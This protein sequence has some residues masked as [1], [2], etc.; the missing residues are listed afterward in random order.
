M[1][2]R[3]KATARDIVSMLAER[4]KEDVFV[5][6]CKSGPTQGSEH[7]RL[8]AWAMAKSWA[9]PCFDG[10]EVKISRSDWLRDA[11]V[12][13][14]LPLCNRLWLVCP[15]G[16]IDPAEVP[17]EIGVLWAPKS[18]GTRLVT[19]R[20][21]TYRQIEPPVDL[22]LY[23]L[24]CRSTIGH[25][26]QRAKTRDERAELWRNYLAGRAE[27]KN[28][29]LSASRKMQDEIQRVLAETATVVGRARTQA[30][31]AKAKLRAM[32]EFKALAVELG[33]AD[34]TGRIRRWSLRSHLD[35]ILTGRELLAKIQA[36][37]GA[38]EAVASA[39]RTITQGPKEH[40]EVAAS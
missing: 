35:E 11:K 34:S 19:K 38:L 20:K 29:G 3:P 32:E 7:L 15:S 23:V 4:H 1:S 10:Y 40:G 30:E 13:L 27:L 22:L 2:D 14:Y 9:H 24:M 5:P 26:Y 28:I 18:G 36:A 39:V 17:M 25:E 8:D 16:L 33:I 6:E 12:H 37:R 21:A 31:D